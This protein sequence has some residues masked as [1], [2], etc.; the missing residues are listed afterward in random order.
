[1]ASSF[2]VVRQLG[3][4]PNPLARISGANLAIAQGEYLQQVKEAEDEKELQR[5]TMFEGAREGFARKSYEERDAR[6]A[7]RE[8]ARWKAQSD[9]E[10]ARNKNALEVEE[11]RYRKALDLE[12]ERITFQ[13][14]KMDE[15]EKTDLRKS[16]QNHGITLPE[17]PSAADIGAAYKQIA[18]G[19]KRDYDRLDAL[20][21]QSSEVQEKADAH[22]NSTAAKAATDKLIADK[23]IPG[24]ISA[25]AQAKLIEKSNSV[26]AAEIRDAYNNAYKEQLESTPYD[27]SA[28]KYFKE[29]VRVRDSLLRTVQI[30]ES[31]KFMSGLR[32][33]LPT[34][35]LPEVPTFGRSSVITP[36][37]GER[38]RNKLGGIGEGFYDLGTGSGAAGFGYGQP[39][40]APTAPTQAFGNPLSAGVDISA[41][42]AQMKQPRTLGPSPFQRYALSIIRD[43]PRF[44]D[45]T[46][47]Q[48]E[49]ID[50]FMDMNSPT[51]PR[52]QA[53]KEQEIELLARRDKKT[54]DALEAVMRMSATEPGYSAIE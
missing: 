51:G 40:T 13:Y 29:A 31:D 7:D 9:R 21:R 34:E 17:N 50:R 4:M 53:Q 18:D 41:E 32:H 48:A 44:K 36:S 25:E 46:P 45:T 39:R 10:D 8:D 37:A 54:I 49:A 16:F 52:T 30:A 20:S 5:R 35:S 15:R 43:I 23:I 47:E 28:I 38:L 26:K 27:P 6:A 42:M 2:D 12:K 22:R 24:G 3:T 1:M 33:L 11:I 14:Q 19:M